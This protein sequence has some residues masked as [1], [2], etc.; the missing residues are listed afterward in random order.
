MRTASLKSRELEHS[1]RQNDGGAPCFM[2]YHGAVQR[3]VSCTLTQWSRCGLADGNI[4][5]TQQSYQRKVESGF[6]QL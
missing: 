4:K 5:L 2:C 3:E 6:R 1:Q